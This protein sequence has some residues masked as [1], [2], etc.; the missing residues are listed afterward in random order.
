MR[1]LRL[2]FALLLASSAC[3]R[4]EAASPGENGP[5]R[6]V[7]IGGAK[8]EGPG[9]H[10]YP[11]GVR[12][13]ERALASSPDAPRGLRVKSYPDG[14]PT[15]PH[16]FDGAA[17]VVWYFDGAEKHPLF[18]ATRRKQFARVLARG[19]GLVALHQSSTLPAGDT[20]V[21]L[22]RW[23]G[24]ARYGM[25]D[26]TTE[27]AEIRLE[28]PNHPIVR[29]VDAFAY[30]DEF[31]PT[32]RRG[33]KPIAPT[34]H[35]TLHVQYRDGAAVVDDRPEDTVVAWTFERDGGGRSFTYS[36]AHF[37][38]AFEVEPLRKMLLNA[39]LWTA[40]AEVPANGMHSPAPPTASEPAAPPRTISAAADVPTF[41]R[42][43]QRS[44]WY[45]AETAL[46]PARIR[47]SSLGLQWESPPLDAVD[48]EPPRLYA[49]PL[50]LDG[51]EISA[52]PFRT[53]TFATVIAASSNGY[54]YAINAQKNGDI[55]P[56]RILW[57]TRLA[58]PCRLQPAPLD[59]V[60]TGVLATPVIDRARNRLYVTSCDPEKR[61]QAYALD[62]GSGA[63][64]AGW[65]VPLDEK[66]FNAL[67]RNA[68]PTP[69]PPK[70]RFDFRVQRGALNLSPD[71]SALYI[72]FG[73]TETGWLVAVDTQRAKVASAFAVSAMPHRGSG[74][75]WGSAGASVDDDGSVFAVTG[76]GFGGYVDQAHDWTQ[77]VLK[78]AYA[79]GALT[80]TG[81]YTPF[82]HCATVANDVDLGSGGIALLP[83]LDAAASA[84]PRLLAVGGKQGNVYLL[85][86]AR[87]PGRLDRRPPCGVNP[88]SDASLLAPE[89]QPQFGRR[90]PLNVFGPYSEQDAALGAARSRSVPAVFRDA[91]GTD[92]V[93]VTGNTKKAPGSSV[94]VAPSLA[95]LEVVARA[96]RPAY[97]QRARTQDSVVLENPG[98]PVVTSNGAN[99][100][101]VWVLD[102]N[103][104]RAAL[105]S[106]EDSPRPVL[107]AFDAMTLDLLW[108]SETGELYTSGKYNEP[109][110]AHGQ[111]FV[112]SDRIQAFGLG[113]SVVRHDVA[114]KNETKES[115]DVKHAGPISGDALYAARCSACHDHAQGAIPPRRQIAARGRTAIVEALTQG[116]MRAQAHGLSNEEIRAIAEYLHP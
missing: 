104:T 60:P 28:Q 72:G 65:P 40:H 113:K 73:E 97:L 108:R 54:V 109:A 6:I 1:T 102:E 69:V 99:D 34:L 86:R 21:D 111:V 18:D 79:D 107:Y 53:Q 10:D 8:S 91:Q 77:S 35:A 24:A 85:D 55:A 30:R 51:L 25:F 56:G 33:G 98:P 59:G 15:D 43:A 116:A 112:G 39:I 57:R 87:L 75:I 31:Y 50:C 84:T 14:W 68:G 49:S 5:F 95:R 3:L 29:G 45:A 70:R 23:L 2:C 46:T 20:S 63:V 93:F 47:A 27:Y 37:L 44:G 96:N 42:D 32:F 4:A 7:L 16:A 83:V 19:V 80:L 9:K 81:T 48:G 100:A 74:G 38:A 13:L 78:F 58:A 64:L 36:G 88:D 110:F 12:L 101:V 106:G 11:A 17:S 67:N 41:H 66:T 89:A 76:T 115:T 94:S 90:G 61:W 114:A 71:G 82:N 22:P 26:R 103:A 105:L 92:H 52:G 62:L